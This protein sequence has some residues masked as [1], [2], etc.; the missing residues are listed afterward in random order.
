MPYFGYRTPHELVIEAVRREVE[1]LINLYY[2]IEE[3]KSKS[4]DMEDK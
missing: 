4:M 2:K 3:I 1:M